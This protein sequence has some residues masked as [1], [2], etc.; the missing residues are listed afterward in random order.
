MK[1][2][3]NNISSPDLVAEAL[4]LLTQ[5]SEDSS[6]RQRE[7][8]DWAAQSPHHAEAMTIAEA[9]WSL[10]AKLPS[11]APRGFER[12]QIGAETVAAQIA[13][14]P[15]QL[16][17]AALA[18]VAVFTAVLLAID[19]VP[20]QTVVRAQSDLVPHAPV[21]RFVR[22]HATASGEQASVV[23]DDGSTVWLNWESE[24]DVEF[25]DSER[26]VDLKRGAAVFD[27]ADDPDR[28]FIVH[29]GDVI[30][31]V[32]GTEFA[33]HKVGD[34]HVVFEVRKGVVAVNAI[35]GDE[36][37][38]L[39]RAEAVTFRHGV[40][41]RPRRTPS[42]AI[43]AW[44]DGLLIFD[45]RPLIEVLLELDRYT[46]ARLHVADIVDPERPVTATFFIDDADGALESLKEVFDLATE[47]AGDG[48][49]S[50]RS[51]PD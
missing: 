6:D 5:C 45:K 29:A 38:Q 31:M 15:A 30:A 33:V 47:S 22:R 13:E 12:F 51:K 2:R 23:L 3:P 16:T 9:E 46:S 39:T 7:L 1:E 49:L 19:P 25:V 41:G 40:L 18:L 8:A 42:D 20:P 36:T 35:E 50:V 10:F 17:A 21:E 34:D 48:G 37:V 14:R 24:I 11:N 26:H 32:I 44:R 27:V 43:G 4:S 28:P